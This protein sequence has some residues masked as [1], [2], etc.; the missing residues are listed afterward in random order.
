V[1]VPSRAGGAALADELP[2]APGDRVLLARADAADG[3]LP[4]RLRERGAIVDDVVAY[5]TI[6]APEAARRPLREAFAHDAPDVLVFSSGSTVRGLLA[7]LPPLERRV[8][9]RTP[10]CCIGPSTAAVAREAGFA[11]VHEAPASS[12][13]AL[14]DLVATILADAPADQPTEV[15]S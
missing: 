7:L 5:H 1:F 11:H 3:A 12:V 6:E 13:A 10:A 9:L 4:E 14:A 8:A 15:T 2:I